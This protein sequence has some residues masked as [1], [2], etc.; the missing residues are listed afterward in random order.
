M[1]TYEYECGACG[2]RFE[3]FQSITAEAIR[4]CPACGAVK[5]RRLI[6]PGGAFIF[7]GSGFYTTDYRSSEYKEKASADKPSSTSEDK[8]AGDTPS[9][10]KKTDKTSES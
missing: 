2:H 6:G 9:K 4:K 3:E 7:K 8:P 5:V 1:P 10:G